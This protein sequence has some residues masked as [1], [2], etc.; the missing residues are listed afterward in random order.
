ARDFLKN[1][2]VDLIFLDI[3][4]PGLSGLQLLDQLSVRPH[5]IFATAYSEYAVD[6]YEYEAAD[7]L[8]KPIEFDRFAKAIQKVKKLMMTNGEEKNGVLS[9]YLFLKD[10]Y[11]QVK[12]CISD[13]HYIQSD[14]NYLNV[15]SGSDRINTR[16][17][18]NQM[19]D[20][21]PSSSFIR[22]HNSYVVNIEQ[23]ERIENNQI[24][25]GEAII[26]IG[27]SFRENLQTYLNK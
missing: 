16:M 21:L 22:V 5:V 20:Q 14:G 27:P 10:G 15:F 26:A 17:T 6:S 13:I 7:Y 25:I 11:K 2:P 8:L 12:I 23:I 3:N 24:I 18:L 4:M 19:I 1:N 9:K